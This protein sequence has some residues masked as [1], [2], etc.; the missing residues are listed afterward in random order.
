[1]L[2]L[3]LGGGIGAGRWLRHRFMLAPAQ[4]ASVNATASPA[5]TDP[6]REVV[7]SVAGGEILFQ[8]HCA[9]CHGPDGQGDPEAVERLRPPPRDFGSRPWRFAVDAATIR[10]LTRDGIPGTAM[11]AFRDALSPSEVESVVDH[12]LRLAV[13]PSSAEQESNSFETALIRAHF[14]PETK[15]RPA[16]RL[17]LS[18]ADGNPST[19]ADQR[20]RWVLLNFWGVSCEHC[21][22]GMPDLQSLAERW[23][24]RGLVVLNVCADRE[25]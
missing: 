25:D 2:A 11:P 17:R 18:D 15:L 5:N 4:G 8:L 7:A 1:M 9:K 3:V 12:T 14:L 24:P 10:R 16:P 13:L 22:S 6:Q 21:L 20:G 23:A 19:L